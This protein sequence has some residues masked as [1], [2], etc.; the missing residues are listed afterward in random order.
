MESTGEAQSVAGKLGVKYR[1]G[2]R[3]HAMRAERDDDFRARLKKSRSAE[4]GNGGKLLGSK[5]RRASAANSS[6]TSGFGGPGYR[7]KTQE[8]KRR[9]EELLTIVSTCFGDVPHEILCAGTDEMLTV[10]KD[11]AYIN[12][13]RAEVENLIGKISDPVY[14][15][16]D[17][18]ASQITDFNT[19]DLAGI[20]TLGAASTASSAGVAIVLDEDDTSDSDAFEIPESDEESSSGDDGPQPSKSASSLPI[21]GEGTYS[22]FNVPASAID[23]HWIQR[24][25]SAF[26]ADANVSREKAEEVYDIMRAAEERTCENKLLITLGPE[27]FDTIK[28]FMKN[29]EKIIYCIRLHRALDETEQIKIKAEMMADATGLGAEV[30]RELEASADASTIGGN[31]NWA[32]N[33]SSRSQQGAI[34]TSHRAPTAN[35]PHSHSGAPTAAIKIHQKIDL[36]LLGFTRG[37]RVMSNED[38]KLPAKSWRVQKK[39]YEEVH[40]P[41]MKNIDHTGKL[42]G[43]SSLPSW[44]QLGFGDKIKRLNPLQSKVFQSAFHSSEN[45]LVCAPTGAGKTNVAFLTMLEVIGRHINEETGLVN[46]QSFKMVYIAPMK[47]LVQETVN[48][49]SHRLAPYKVNVRELS[50]DQAL[51]KAEI[52][53]TQLIVTTP[54]KWDIVTRKAG[55]RSYTQL[56]RLIIIDEIHLLHD[57]RGPVLESL[58]ARTLRRVEMTQEPV[59]LVG[60]S[61]TLPNYQDVADFLRINPRSGLFFFDGS[62]RPVPLQQQ[63]IG[64]SEKKVFKRL[65]LQ[66]EITYD[67]IIGQEPG[68]QVLVFVHS[69]KDTVKTAKALRDLAMGKSELG[70][71]VQQDSATQ[72]ILKEQASEHVANL[73]LKDIIPYGFGVH[74]A[75]LTKGDRTLVE[76]LFRDGRL[77]VLVSTATLAWGVNLPAH[78]VIIKGT[79]VYDPEKGSWTELSSQDVMQMIGRAGRPGYDTKGE[80]VIITSQDELQFYLSLLNEQLPIESQ[81]VSKLVDNLNAEIVSGAVKHVAEAATW[82]GYT[83]Y[84]ARMLRSPKLYGVTPAMIDE[85]PILNKHR[86]NLIHSAASILD[87]HGLLHYDRATGAFQAT[88]LGR[89]ASYYYITID[90]VAAFNNMLSPTMDDIGLFRLFSSSY[91]FRNVVVRS[92]EKLELKRLLQRVPIP[93]KE[94]L[95]NASAKINVLLQAYISRLKLDGYALLSDMVYIQASAGR[96]MRAIF[97]MVI[98]RGWADLAKRVLKLSNM[99]ERRMWGS[100]CP[101]RQFPSGSIN[102]DILTSLE[103]KSLAW[104]RYFDLEPY[105][106]G[107]LVRRPG[108]GRK[109]YSFVHKF[110]KLELSAQIQP[111]LRSMLKMDLIIMADFEYDADMLGGESLQFHIF[112]EDGN[113]EDILHHEMFSLRKRFMADEHTI[114]LTVPMC[115]PPAPQYYIRVIADRWL[116]A[117]A[118]LPV[119]FQK[120]TLPAPSAP[121]TVLLDLAPLPTASL[122]VPE[123]VQLF[124]QCRRMEL[125]NS[126]QTQTFSALFESDDN[127]LVCAPSGNDKMVCAEVAMM[128]TF[129]LNPAAR[130]VYVCALTDICEQRFTQWRLM[131]GAGG[132]GKQIVMLTGDTESDTALMQNSH[133]VV[134]DCDAWDLISRRWKQRKLVN[135]ISLLIVDELHMIGGQKGPTLETIVARTRI[136]EA[137]F[138]R[139]IRVIGLSSPVV[140]AKDL[141]NWMGAKKSRLFAFGMSVRQIPLKLSCIAFQENNFAARMVSMS[142]PAYNAIASTPASPSERSIIFV[143]SRQQAALVALDMMAFC[144]ADTDPSRFVGDEKVVQLTI[145]QSVANRALAATLDCGIGFIHEAQSHADRDIVRQLY[146]DGAIKLLV[147]ARSQLWKMSSFS[148]TNVVIMGC[149]Y[150]D[151]REHRYVKYPITDVLEMIGRAGQVNIE[152]NASCTIMCHTSNKSYFEKFMYTPLPVESHLDHVLHNALCSEIAVRAITNKQEAMDY[153]TWS[154]LYRRLV[155]NP[156]Y[157]N[158]IGT[159]NEEI[160]DHLSEL[161]ESALN[162][163]AESKC[164]NIIDDMELEPL[165][166]GMISSYHYVQY[167]TVEL[168]ASSLT[169]NTQLR[170]ILEVVSASAEFESLSMRKSEDRLLQKIIA[171]EPTVKINRPDWSEPYTKVNALLQLYFSRATISSPDLLADLNIILLGI[172]RVIRALVDV[173]SSNGWLR[174]LLNAMEFSQMVTQAQWG[175]DSPLFQLP[176][177]DR[178][179][180]QKCSQMGIQGVFDLMD[181]EDEPRNELLGLS[182]SQMVDVANFCNDYPSLE[183]K[184]SVENEEG[185]RVETPVTVNVT[186]EREM[187]EDDDGNVVPYEEIPVHATHYPPRKMQGW[188]LVIGDSNDD[189]VMAIKKV[190]LKEAISTQMEFEAPDTSGEHIYKLYLMCDSYVGCDQEYEL[191][192][193]VKD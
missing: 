180:A 105:D 122:Q 167:T 81:F 45:L 9:Y 141:G 17:R 155:K 97:E 123:Y 27:Q 169:Q 50:G 46:T 54:E 178:E 62:F 89:I 175:N 114:T 162:D 117:E 10:L 189:T 125:F 31:D 191:K 70:R 159:S 39:G 138:K 84:F 51:T 119:S 115:D 4:Q 149:S 147:V 55:E 18:L 6:L 37:A 99:I 95:E 193:N 116:Q 85:D 127:V 172:G 29:R 102:K 63:Y 26:Y 77:Q 90:S 106:L 58:V 93:V 66:N 60:L 132:L 163:L 21:P 16:I 28:M 126:V 100:Q 110:P 118:V 20:D 15:S 2:D 161:V 34:D 49:F 192:I 129:S 33:A 24:T 5:G 151:G 67:K 179:L 35:V 134:C 23:S 88:E 11:D 13:R 130:C 3:L 124:Q 128:R 104:P 142:K 82:L 103:K 135:E 68:N 1:M 12:K 59:R 184:A 22:K 19:K 98:M 177:F 150:Y 143:N 108:F 56:V 164:I 173:I 120:L 157:Y 190:K 75:G 32:V 83:Y 136:M 160:S 154:F 101:L 42:V 65:A 79:Q 44:A 109:L 87:Q 30:L 168:F 131:F 107:E 187:D 92:E 38:V 152:D 165:N 133:I 113:G 186:I 72:E 52:A 86:E 140:N 148:A 153:L 146:Q 53:D 40:V 139:K 185:I 96:I 76:D 91:E 78:C 43:I 144:A 48:N 80:G 183:L 7:P 74:H 61:A 170:G 182:E 174:T 158:L 171:H 145:S 137:H 121:P 47:A 94:D 64:I 8:T 73:D 25:L 112:V 176:H 69:R 166:M 111:I 181:M 156:N 41:A 71:F 14:H 57:S 36:S 188:W